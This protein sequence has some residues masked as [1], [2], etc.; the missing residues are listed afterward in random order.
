MRDAERNWINIFISF[1][2]RVIVHIIPLLVGAAETEY[3]LVCRNREI[4]FSIKVAHS[5]VINI[6]NDSVVIVNF[7]HFNL[8][9]FT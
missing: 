6:K 9:S 1:I 7:R 4:K 2:F 5:N 8:L 3:S